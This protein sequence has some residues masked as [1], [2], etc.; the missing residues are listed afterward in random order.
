[1]TWRDWTKT[2]REQRE[3]EREATILDLHLRCWTQDDIA[4]EVEISRESVN[5]QIAKFGKSGD[6]ADSTIFR[7]FDQEEMSESGRRIYDVWNFNEA[8]NEVRIFGNIPPEI[9]DNLLYLYTEPFD[10]VFDPFGGAGST[11][12][13][14]LERKR[15][16][17]ISDLTVIPERQDDIIQHDITTGLGLPK[18]LVPKLVFLDPPYWQQAKGRYSEQ[19]TD[20]GNMEL[21]PFLITLGNIARDIKRKWAN[22]G[23][24]LACIIGPWKEDQNKVH[25]PALVY[26]RMS[27]YL[28]LKEW[29]SVPYSTQIHG[30][31]FVK[32]AKIQRDLLYL[33]RH[34]LVFGL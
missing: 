9:I 29:I 18:G 17:Y 2:A 21:E 15:R 32:M 12:D 27:K 14:C 19:T 20:L 4:Q 31:A 1:V 22:G 34:L 11:L 6:F 3:A 5:D 10:V 13:K 7:D 24:T 25:L 33:N 28:T 30:G 26:E 16:C 23:G 8:K